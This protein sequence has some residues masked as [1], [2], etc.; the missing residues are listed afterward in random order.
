VHW[1]PDWLPWP[2]CRQGALPVAIKINDDC[3]TLEINGK[4]ISE[5]RLRPDDWW[6]VDYWPRFF[7]RNQ[8]IT[9]LTITELLE[10]GH[11]SDSPVVAALREELR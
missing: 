6:K 11:P 4:V 8:A 2:P 3:M 5:A 10:V 9:A 7:R 1:L